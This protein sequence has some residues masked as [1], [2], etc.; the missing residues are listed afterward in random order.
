[1]DFATATPER[2][3]LTQFTESLRKLTEKEPEA[4]VLE[5]GTMRW[6]DDFPTH[7]RALFPFV[8]NYVM[9]D[10]GAGLDVDFRADLHE[11]STVVGENT[12]DAF[13]ACSVWEH[14]KKPWVAA[15]EVVKIL[16]PGGFFF[17]QTHSTFPLHGYPNDYYRFSTSALAS[18]FEGPCSVMRV[19]Y[20][21]PAKIVSMRDPNTERFPA[22]LNVNIYGFKNP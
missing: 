17:I 8:K 3:C 1:M 5:A 20:E 11:I 2:S 16:K 6:R 10:I 22:F 14:L 9:T 12:F 13:L 7:H 19:E 4:R 15:E 18:L 21:F